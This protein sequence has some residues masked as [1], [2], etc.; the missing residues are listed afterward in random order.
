MRFLDFHFHTNRQK[1]TFI[2][3]IKMIYSNFIIPWVELEVR[4]IDTL[5]NL[6]LLELRILYWEQAILSLNPASPPLNQ[7]CSLFDHYC[8]FFICYCALWSFHEH[9]LD[10]M[11]ITIIF[12][13]FH[14]STMCSKILVKQ[15]CACA[16]L[17]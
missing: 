12:I 9:K 17:P 15:Q 5:T 14:V 3:I 6:N 2:K 4:N 8:F 16:I 11:P 7:D 10:N 13:L 1:I